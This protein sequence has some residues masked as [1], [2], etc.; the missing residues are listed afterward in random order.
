MKWPV[1]KLEQAA[2]INPRSRD[3]ANLP[4]ETTVGFVPMAA[5]S[6]E[7]VSI[8]KIEER[9][10]EAVR[11]GFTPFRDED[12]LFA[13][14][15]PCMENGKA[16]L[17]RNLPNGLGFGSTEF[18]V[19]RA[20]KGVLP[21]FLFYFIR[22]SS[23]RNDA[24]QRFRGAAGQ[25]R[26]PEDFLTGYPFPLPAPRE[27]R[28]IVEL[29]EHAD[30]LRRQRNVADEMAARILP[31][32]F[33]KMFGEPDR[34]PRGWPVVPLK[35]LGTP[36]SGGAFPLDEQGHL[37]GEIPF[38][39]VSDMNLPGNERFILNANHWVS[40]ETLARLGVKPA[41]QKTIVFPKIGA[42]IATNKKRM[43]TRETAFDNNVQGVV[44]VKPES[45]F[46]LFAFFLRFDL[47]RL[48]RVTTLPSIRP[49][50][51]AVLPI[52]NPPLPLQKR[53]GEI[54][55]QACGTLVEQAEANK[56]LG[57]LFQTMLHHA[58][59][60]ELTAKWREAHLKEL[61]VEM[62]HQAKLLRTAA[63]NN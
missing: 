51:L 27:Q 17:A 30:G 29:L 48:A 28:R 35:Q 3:W 54:Y 44:P 38:I 33:H 26:V 12:V 39:K 53:F 41:P 56:T 57:N 7:T 34:N 16:A 15:T 52:P 36:W 20:R 46:Y 62:E 37:S 21:Q 40:R 22:Q 59:T 23:F 9:S 42:A 45:A 63:E 47:M 5:V 1:I 18:H 8:E 31:A 10:L 49:T 2:E 58:F 32:L 14:I 60:G 55:E 4:A 13:K 25:Q 61:L 6:Q 19:L 43:L 11:K 50:E 24:K